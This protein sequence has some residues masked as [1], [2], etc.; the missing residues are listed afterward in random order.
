MQ[1]QYVDVK[2]IKPYRNNPRK[3]DRGISTVAES[4]EQYGF[5]QPI[6]VDQNWEIIVGHTRFSAAKQLGYSQV[7]VLVAADLTPQQVHAYRL[8]DNRSNQN[9]FWD[10]EILKGELE[11]MMDTLTHADIATQTGFT[12]AEINKMFREVDTS[13]VDVDPRANTTRTKTGDVWYLGEHVLACGDSNDELLIREI[14]DDEKISLIWEDPPYGIAYVSANM[15]N[16]TS[17]EEQ[18]WI[19]DNQ[20]KDDDADIDTLTAQLREHLETLKLYSRPGTPIYWCHDIRFNRE[21]HDTLTS[22]G[23]HVSDTLIWRKQNASNWMA[24]YAK[25]YEPILYGWL[26]N[27]PHPWYGYKMN[28]NVQDSATLDDLD[29]DQLLK[30]LKSF[31]TN[32]QEVD[33]LAA[34]KTRKMH[35]TVKPPKLIEAHIINSTKTGEIVFDGFSGSGSTIIACESTGRRARSIEINPIYVDRTIQRWQELT[36]QE[37]V[38]STGATYASRVVN[39]NL[40]ED[41][42][43][44]LTET[45]DLEDWRDE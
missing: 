2:D 33:R 28:R 21:F 44:N 8:M 39:G 41:I 24:D 43:D 42:M 25:V 35:P 13:D 7:P 1:I 14:L 5:Q 10:N 6:V 23:F 16:K 34:T 20:I 31:S 27:G 37:A 18:Q 12:E 45:F 22:T 38:D 4:I 26:K 30:I 36:G 15:V 32:V 17:A 11:S 40:H 3:I 9:T 29:R 19:Q